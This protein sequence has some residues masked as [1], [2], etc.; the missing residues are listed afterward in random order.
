MS[1]SVSSTVSRSMLMSLVAAGL[2]TLL[3]GSTGCAVPQKPGLGKCMRVVEPSTKTPYWLYLPEEYVARRGE[4]PSRER[5]PTVVTFHGMIPYDTAN[6]Q[7]RE[8]QEEADRYGFVVVAPE[9]RTCD[10]FMQYPLKDASLPYVRQDEK[11][12]LSVM[13]EVFRRTNADPNHVLATSFSCGGYLAHYFV[14][15]YPER[16]SCLALR[17]SNFSPDLLA[18]SQ[19][20]KYRDMPIGVFFGENDFKACFEESMDAVRWYRRH[21]FKVEAKKVSGLG[22]ERKP[23]LA[24]ALFARTM[25][26]VPRTPPDL[27]RLVMMDIPETSTELVSSRQ[28]GARRRSSR[29]RVQTDPPTDTRQVAPPQ[30][31]V[32]Y[33]PGTTRRRARSRQPVRRETIQVAPMNPSERAI[34][35]IDPPAN[36]PATPRRPLPAQPY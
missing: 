29:Q 5:W 7:I 22:H 34:P 8:W 25:N 3:S 21:R 11:A 17:G 23:Q 12:V 28:L 2:L 26:I 24:A 27:G 16:F 19:I 14:N 13:D 36:R 10:S 35:V 30:R 32:I 15:R 9:L 33:R 6:A 18:T 1:L 20:P 4:H 31:D